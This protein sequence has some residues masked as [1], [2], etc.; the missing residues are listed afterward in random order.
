MT[1]PRFSPFG[2]PLVPFDRLT[3]EEKVHLLRA[4]MGSWQ[5][6]RCSAYVG[7]MLADGLETFLRD[8]GDLARHLG[9]RPAK[10]STATAGRIERRKE[11]DALLVRLAV[12]AGSGARAHRILRG[13]EPCPKA[14]K[15]VVDAL[16]R[17]AVPKS[18]AAISRA[19]VSRLR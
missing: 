18:R 8:G 16:K 10:G 3:L 17:Y 9:L 12:A 1:D 2:M 5:Y 15:P 7:R 11:R 4:D 19:K 14:C 13:E 6:G